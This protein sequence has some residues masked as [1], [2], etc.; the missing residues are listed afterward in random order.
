[1]T[2]TTQQAAD[3]LG[4]TRPT[5][6]NILDAGGIP[7]HRVGTHRRLRL[8]DVLDYRQRRR[9]AQYATLEATASELDEDDVDMDVVLRA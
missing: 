8:V 5:V 6:I 4:M 1:M 2:L 3:L 9:A 7:F